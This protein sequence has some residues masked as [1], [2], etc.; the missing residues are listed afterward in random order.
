MLL[1]CFT[2]GFSPSR[3]CRT[4]GFWLSVRESNPLDINRS[5]FVSVRIMLVERGSG[6]LSGCYGRCTAARVL[7]ATF[8]FSTAQVSKVCLMPC[9]E[10]GRFKRRPSF[11]PCSSCLALCC[12]VK[13]HTKPSLRTSPISA[14]A[15]SGRMTRNGV[16]R[17]HSLC[18]N[19]PNVAAHFFPSHLS[20]PHPVASAGSGESGPWRPNGHR[21]SEIPR[22]PASKESF[23]WQVSTLD[24][25][26]EAS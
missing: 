10:Y 8:Q 16:R 23:G 24:A 22:S 17:L 18:R 5:A 1:R 7:R 20:H 4:S 14:L 9:A 19:G 11:E 6:R 13:V 25:S 2:S 15:C 12:P 21:D 3:R 26:S